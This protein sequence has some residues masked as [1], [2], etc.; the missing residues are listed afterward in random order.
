MINFICMDNDEELQAG[1]ALRSP[2]TLLIPNRLGVGFS[3]TG[4]A[5]ETGREVFT[6]R[7]R[8]LFVVA[9]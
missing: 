3:E 7:E 5:T 4:T 6:A 1:M 2:M 8:S 9:V